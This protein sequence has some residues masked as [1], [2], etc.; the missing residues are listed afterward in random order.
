[1]TTV[2]QHLARLR[3]QA[4]RE[5]RRRGAV[6]AVVEVEREELR[7]LERLG[8]LVPGDRDGGAVAQAVARFLATADAVA[9]IGEAL[10]PAGV[11]NAQP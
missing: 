1:M 7:A 10:Y 11:G 3:S 5:R 8:L 9:G 6:V 4:Y 2:D